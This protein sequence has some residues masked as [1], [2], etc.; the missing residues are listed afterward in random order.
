MLSSINCQKTF[1]PPKVKSDLEA[2]KHD[3]E[4]VKAYGIQLA[5]ETCQ[6]IMKIPS[7]FSLH[8]YTMNLSYAVTEILRRLGMT[9]NEKP[10]ELPRTVV[11]SKKDE[12]RPIFWSKQ[13]RGMSILMEDGVSIYLYKELFTHVCT[14]T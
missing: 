6:K 1:V 7:L 3:D 2:I 8:F 13:P 12:V 5:V 11:H 9:P 10:R 14:C 4:A